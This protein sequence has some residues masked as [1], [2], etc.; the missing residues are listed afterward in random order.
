MVIAVITLIA[1]M[2]MCYIGSSVGNIGIILFPVSL[3][4]F[5]IGNNIYK[6][7]QKI[8]EDYFGNDDDTEDIKKA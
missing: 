3:L 2:V 4:I 5:W 8:T 7:G 6:K 1:S